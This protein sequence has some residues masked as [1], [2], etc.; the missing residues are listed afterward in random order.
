MPTET[1]NTTKF[2]MRLHFFPRNFW[3]KDDA[4]ASIDTI[5]GVRVCMRQNNAERGSFNIDGQENNQEQQSA[6]SKKP[7]KWVRNLWTIIALLLITLAA[8]L[9]FMNI[10][11]RNISYDVQTFEVEGLPEELEGLR[12]AFVSDIHADRQSEWDR[13]AKEV[14]TINGYEPDI[15]LLGGDY[16]DSETAERAVFNQ[17]KGLRHGLGVFTVRGN[18][19][20][21]A[22]GDSFWGIAREASITPINNESFRVEKNGKQIVIAGVDDYRLGNSD[23]QSALSQ[24]SED[25]FCIFLSH[26]PASV[27]QAN[28]EGLTDKIDLALVGHTH[29][30]QFTLFG[31]WSPWAERSMPGFG[32]QWIDIGDVS[33]LYSNG[34][35][36]KWEFRFCARPQIHII[37]LTAKQA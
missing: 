33:T 13:L 3:R 11:S 27:L 19:D 4:S 10:Q 31:L 15:I 20:V 8:L 23:P 2:I 36:Q 34:M 21:N 25:D 30:G 32:S 22:V 7:R 1:K 35:G 18:H 9:L 29:G 24:V 5:K 17:L 37:T 14:E 12:L 6:S 28:N 16:A 26:E